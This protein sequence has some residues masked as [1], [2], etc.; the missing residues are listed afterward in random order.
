ML[1]FRPAVLLAA[2]GFGAMAQ[3]HV[4]AYHKGWLS[5]SAISFHSLT[6]AFQACTAATAFR[7][8]PVVL[9]V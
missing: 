1:D 5:L 7:R 4:A 9:P 6:T 2:L 3:A 8:F